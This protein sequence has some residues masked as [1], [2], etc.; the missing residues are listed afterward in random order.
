MENLLIVNAPPNLRE[1]LEAGPPKYVLKE[2]ARLH[3]LEAATLPRI[4]A[5]RKRLGWK[6]DE[7]MYGQQAVAEYRGRI[8]RS[9]ATAARLAK[10][11]ETAAEDPLPRKP[12]MQTAL[13]AEPQA[14]E[15]TL[16]DYLPSVITVDY[17]ERL[18]QNGMLGR[19]S[20]LVK[21]QASIE[22]G[23]ICA[24]AVVRMLQDGCALTREEAGDAARTAMRQIEIGNYRLHHMMEEVEGEARPPMGPEP[25]Y[26]DVKEVLCLIA[27]SMKRAM[28][29]MLCDSRLVIG[30]IADV[31][32]R[33]QE[34]VNA[35]EP[36]TCV[37]AGLTAQQRQAGG[38]VPDSHWFFGF[39]RIRGPPRKR[40]AAKAGAPTKRGNPRGQKRTMD[41]YLS[42]KAPIDVT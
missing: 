11:A 24:E 6:S 4:E 7:E 17:A 16:C 38:Y 32:T 3:E 41:A 19:G 31:E 25:R 9:A 26:L 21:L 15:I 37:I 27:L 34:L 36:A 20:Q 5:A 28:G 2:M 42:N 8:A 23:Y 35:G 13:A 18:Q 14:A 33:V 10:A 40:V 22:C 1:I 29:E 30:P 12:Q 39:V